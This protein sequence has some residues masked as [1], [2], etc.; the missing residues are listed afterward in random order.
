MR[1]FLAFVGLAV[2]GFLALPSAPAAA[3]PLG[4][5]SVNRYA[6]LTLHPDRVDAVVVADVAELPTLQDPAPSCTEAADALVVTVSGRRLP[7][8]VGSSDLTLSDG[9]GGLQTSRLDCRL[10][11]PASFSSRAAITVDN[12]FRADRI[13]WRELTATGAGVRLE[14]STVPAATVS[15]ELRGYPDDLLSSP[16]DVRTAMF[17]A[18]AD[19][20]AVAAGATAS[21]SS[22]AAPLG[23]SG[24]LAGAER[25]LDSVVGGARLTPLVGLLAVLLALLLGAAHAALPG[26]GKTVMAA[27]LAGRAGRPRDAVAV[28]ATVTLTHT[29]GVLAL[30]LLLTTFAGIAGESVLAWLG[31]VSG[32]IV[33]AIG[34]GALVSALR[35]RSRNRHAATHDHPHDHSHSH[36]HDHGHHHGPGHSHS[37]GPG[38]WGIAGIGVAGGLV[39]SPSALVVLLGA[40]ALGR[41]AFGVLLVFAYGLGMAATLTAAGLLLIRVRDRFAGRLRLLERWQLAAPSATA[42]LIV[43]VGL[44]LAGRA[45]STIA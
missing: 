33:A 40:I 26:H 20:A 27:Y 15:A 11:A 8:T 12:G 14:G 44:G 19:G 30:G 3:H 35:R 16:P 5:F 2:V 6:G 42:A 10:T 24:P 29:G 28:G 39:P 45:L 23:L 1:R 32:G 17:S 43:V 34:V 37:H 25:W 7:W 22:G 36:D 9:A 38:K 21:Q 31:V 13:G 18:V 41:T 4:N